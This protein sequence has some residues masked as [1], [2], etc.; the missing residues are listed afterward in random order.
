MII[1]RV[2]FGLLVLLVLSTCE[3]METK[4]TKYA[5]YEAVRKAGEIDRGWIPEFLPLSAKNIH[6][7]H[8]IDTNE[9]WLFF[10]F[11][12]ST[13]IENLGKSCKQVT[14]HNI[15]FPR[16]PGGWWPKE[17]TRRTED[18]QSTDRDYEYYRCEDDGIIAIDSKN[19]KAFYWHLG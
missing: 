8:N 10:N 12:Y 4:E 1:I 13:D 16:Y 15:V 6:E 7:R 9:V 5:N 2:L 11:N 17:L 14:S 19:G 3:K 18:T